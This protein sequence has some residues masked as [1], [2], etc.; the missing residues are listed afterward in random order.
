MTR[1]KILGASLSLLLLLGAAGACGP[2]H[3]VTVE[4]VNQSLDA[5]R[6]AYQQLL[7][8]NPPQTLEYTS[9]VLLKQAEDLAAKKD[10]TQ[11]QAVADQA[12]AQAMMAHQARSQMI[13]EMRKRLERCRNELELMYFPGLRL[14]KMYW[15][16]LDLLAAKDYD[17]ARAVVDRLEPFIA[18]EKQLSFYDSR[19]AT[20][21]A[22]EDDVRRF[23]HP[24]LYEK[25]LTDCTLNNVVDTVEPGKQVKYIRMLLCNRQRTFYQVENPRTGKQGWIAE[26]YVSTR[27]E[28]H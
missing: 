23:G 14:V 8:L 21:W 7:E 15:E 26:R 10:Y 19:T 18:Q 1:A 25:V 13:E 9:R 11:A 3:R 6:A 4:Q 16:A 27:D 17:S 5:A 2:K 12:L 28:R 22:D 24:R 20:V